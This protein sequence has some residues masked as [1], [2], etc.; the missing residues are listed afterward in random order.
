[1]MSFLLNFFPVPQT[2]LQDCG[3]QH[4]PVLDVVLGVHVGFV[5]FTKTG[6]NNPLAEVAKLKGDKPYV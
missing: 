4:L 2:T 6:C 1:M 5:P 3:K